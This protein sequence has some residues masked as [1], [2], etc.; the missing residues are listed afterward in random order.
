MLKSKG[1][2]KVRPYFI[3]ELPKSSI[4]EIQE[5]QREMEKHTTDN[6]F[7]KIYLS[8]LSSLPNSVLQPYGERYKQEFRQVLQENYVVNYNLFESPLHAIQDKQRSIEKGLRYL[9]SKV[10]RNRLMLKNIRE[11]LEPIYKNKELEVSSELAKFPRFEGPG[12]SSSAY[13]SPGQT[14]FATGGPKH[15]FYTIYVQGHQ[16]QNGYIPGKNTLSRSNKVNISGYQDLGWENVAVKE[17]KRLGHFGD[18]ASGFIAW[19]I[20]HLAS[21]QEVNMLKEISLWLKDMIMRTSGTLQKWFERE[22]QFISMVSGPVQANLPRLLH[23]KD[24][25][26]NP[27]V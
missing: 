2:S 9:Y 13:R 12:Y 4:P 20:R 26:W 19:C 3:D 5:L 25:K 8:K 18:H 24:N 1:F 6:M 14:A 17:I 21:Y 22:I 23:L 27:T 10:E 7:Y 11:I 16:S 15:G